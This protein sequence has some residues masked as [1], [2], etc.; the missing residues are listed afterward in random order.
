MQTWLDAYAKGYRLRARRVLKA[1]NAGSVPLGDVREMLLR[2]AKDDG[3]ALK[4]YS[5]ITIEMYDVWK[6]GNLRI[7]H[8]M[9]SQI[10]WQTT[11]ARF[12]LPLDS[13]PPTAAVLSANV[14]NALSG[15][16]I[17]RE[18]RQR[19]R[20]EALRRKLTYLDLPDRSLMIG[21]GMQV[22]ALFIGGDRNQNGEQVNFTAILTP[23][24]QNNWRRIG[25]TEDK[26]IIINDNRMNGSLIYP[27]VC[28]PEPGNDFTE[29][30]EQAAVRAGVVINDVLEDIES[31]GLLALTYMGTAEEVKDQKPWPIVSYAPLDD[32]R[33]RGRNAQEVA[34]KFSFFKAYKIGATSGSFERP[35]D[36]AQGQG[37]KL[38]RRTEVRGHFRLQPHGPGG[39]LRRLRWISPHIRGPRDGILSTN[40]LRFGAVNEPEP[41]GQAA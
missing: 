9:M 32:A 5:T 8:E 1:S 36:T 34:K 35:V 11:I 22:R 18:I 19:G 24:G 15:A 39:T 28:S 38:G 23:P 41:V 21:E 33:R 26:R 4:L 25:W 20:A 6:A 27:L 3:C 10:L 14:V 7:T 2:A 13:Q 12:V 37:R 31:F 30:V 29:P 16:T 17:S 40:L